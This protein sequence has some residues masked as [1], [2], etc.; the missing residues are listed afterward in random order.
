[1]VGSWAAVDADGS[2]IGADFADDGVFESY[3]R[4]ATTCEA[5]GLEPSP[6]SW[7]GMWTNDGSPT[8]PV[9][10]DTTCYPVSGDPQT[11]GEGVELLF[12]YEREDDIVVFLP[13]G[14]TFVRVDDMI[15]GVWHRLT[16][17]SHEVTFCSSEASEVECSSVLGLGSG[18]SVV[19]EFVGSIVEDCESFDPGICEG[20]V[21][22]AA[23]VAAL[24]F[25]DGAPLGSVEQLL[26]V[27]EDGR[28]DVQWT[29]VLS[30]LGDAP[31]P[32]HC[33]WYRTWANA[34]ELPGECTLQ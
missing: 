18:D 3:D 16:D 17:G 2:A 5:L 6:W 20:A 9:I 28:L 29:N 21:S 13:D 26:V 11:R 33:P 34:Q 1:M 30:G 24:S 8:V 14:T 7:I 22:V 27:Q 10:G 4:S 32:F 15:D 31:T 23:G 12:E 25:S 19:G